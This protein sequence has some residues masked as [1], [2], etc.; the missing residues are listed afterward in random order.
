MRTRR[1]LLIRPL[2][3][4]LLVVLAVAACA[5]G[6]SAPQLGP[7]GDA[8]GDQEGRDTFGGEGGAAPS[9]APA[10]AADDGT[11]AV[12]DDAKI[13]RTG[14]L[15]LQVTDV[16]DATA[17]ARA[18]IA[19]LGGYIG[20][21]QISREGDET[22]ATVTYRIPSNRWDD[23]LEALRALATEVLYEQTDA[24]EVTSQ[25][26]DLDARIT[27]LRASERALQAIASQATRIS[28]VLEVEARLTDVRGEIERLVAQKTGLEDQ[29]GYGT[30]SVTFGVDVVAVTRAVERWDAADEFDRATASLVDVLQGLASAGI[31]FAIVWLPILVALSVFALIVLLVFR[32]L[33]IVRRGPANT[34]AALPPVPPVPPA[35][36]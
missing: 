32:R 11:T 6:A 13:I 28:D 30:L 5:S 23:G 29:V 14:Q 34:G 21:S 26:V 2:V 24:I 33:G 17:R 22:Y 12:V 25:I 4:V 16:A 31:W 8:I 20:S 3:G 18:A 36:A 15:Q 10:P 27:N 19:G 9:A 7:V 35:E 1:S